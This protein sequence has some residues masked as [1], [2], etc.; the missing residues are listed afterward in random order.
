MKQAILA[1]RYVKE[2]NYLNHLLRKTL[3]PQPKQ[4]KVI[5]HRIVRIE[6]AERGG[7]FRRSLPISS[8]SFDEAQHTCDAVDMDVAG[9]N[10][11]GRTDGVPNAKIDPVAVFADHPAQEHVQALARGLA[12][13]RGY[14]LARAYGEIF[15]V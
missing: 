15:G 1:I 6:Q 5:L 11:L 8:G 7:K 13:G 14:V 3:D 12:R 9:T 2:Y 4:R 10:E